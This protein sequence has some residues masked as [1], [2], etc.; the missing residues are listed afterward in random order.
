[1][2]FKTNSKELVSYTTYKEGFQVY[3]FWIQYKGCDPDN[4]VV[5]VKSQIL[6]D[7]NKSCNRN[8]NCLFIRK[9]KPENKD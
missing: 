5:V 2:H 4:F 9:V 7:C 1:M 6:T 8:Y 3:R